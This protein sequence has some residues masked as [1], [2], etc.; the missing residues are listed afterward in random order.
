MT[1]D[2]EQVKKFGFRA[3]RQVV[4]DDADQSMALVKKNEPTKYFAYSSLTDIR[5]LKAVTDVLIHISDETHAGKGRDK[6]IVFGSESDR[7]RSKSSL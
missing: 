5:P 7:E 3:K 2:V 4:L 1:F 6:H